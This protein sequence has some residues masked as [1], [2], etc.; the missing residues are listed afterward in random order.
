[1]SQPQPS[2]PLIEPLTQREVEVMVL[3]SNPFLERKEIADRLSISPR[4]LDNHLLSIYQK[5]LVTNQFSAAVK[6]QRVYPDCR[7]LVDLEIERSIQEIG[8]AV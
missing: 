7:K 5:L 1:M 4:T 3:C 2:Q 6:F 8:M